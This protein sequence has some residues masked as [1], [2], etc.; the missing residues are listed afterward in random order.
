[1]PRKLKMYI[2]ILQV[3]LR[4]SGN[5]LEGLLDVLDGVRHAEAQVA[6]AEISEGGAG[7]R[8]D[9]GV[10]EQ[11]VGKFLRG[12][13]SFLDAGENVER[14]LGLAAGESFDV[15]QSGHHHVAT[16]LELG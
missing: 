7:E 15:V 10:I 16:A 11:R 13:S 9:A 4:P 2:E 5:A 14:A 12:P 8:G 1:M 3:L 6:F